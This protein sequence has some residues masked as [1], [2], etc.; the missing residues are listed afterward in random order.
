MNASRQKE[1]IRDV[2]TSKFSLPVW[3][4][5]VFALAILGFVCFVLLVLHQRHEKTE[6]AYVVKAMADLATL[7][8]AI[9][10]FRVDCDRY[11]TATEGFSALMTQP[12]GLASWRG[13]YFQESIPLDPW[14]RPYLYQTPGSD[15]KTGYIVESYGADG[16]PGG[17]YEAADIVDGT[18]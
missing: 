18:P 16:E 13:P 12:K 9:D 2:G 6:N 3:L 10:R 1:Q 15:G 14:G 17:D 11:P 4:Q 8:D 5:R 7:R